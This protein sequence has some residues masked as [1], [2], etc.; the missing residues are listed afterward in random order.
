MMSFFS[1]L[2]T[3]SS[4]KAATEI[5]LETLIPTAFGA[6]IT[7]IIFFLKRFISQSDKTQTENSDAKSEIRVITKELGRFES[8]EA[9]QWVTLDNN[10]RE[11]SD[12]KMRV[13][14]LESLIRKL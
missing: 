6:L 11:L 9:K 8:S 10:Q 7:A 5:S 3:S 12:L 1:F 2:P 13:A 14:V 4:I